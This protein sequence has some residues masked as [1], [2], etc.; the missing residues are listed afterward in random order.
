ML[1]SNR[2]IAFQVVQLE[3]SFVGR[4]SNALRLKLQ[5]EGRVKIIMDRE[6]VPQTPTCYGDFVHSS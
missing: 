2:V 4:I 5:N 6:K 1:T 3:L